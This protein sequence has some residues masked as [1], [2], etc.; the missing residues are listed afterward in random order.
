MGVG[1]LGGVGLLL[2]AGGEHGPNH[3]EVNLRHLDILNKINRISVFT[4]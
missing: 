1:L 2:A 4:K 3:L